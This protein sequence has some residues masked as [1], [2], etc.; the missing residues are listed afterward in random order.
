MIR[1]FG[2]LCRLDIS[3]RSGG[4]NFSIPDFIG[5]IGAAHIATLANLQALNISNGRINDEGEAELLKLPNLRR[6]DLCYNW[7]SWDFINQ[8]GSQSPSHH[9]Q[10]RFGQ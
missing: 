8:N 6:L 9:I 4:S 10:V 3:F 1:K 7:L 2:N 5:S